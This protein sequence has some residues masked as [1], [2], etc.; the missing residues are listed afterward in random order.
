MFNS[1]QALNRK[2]NIILL[3]FIENSEQEQ[4][5][6]E[7]RKLCKEV[8]TVLRR[9]TWH[10]LFNKI[11][12]PV[13]IKYFYSEEM[14]EKAK[15]C[16]KYFDIDLVQ[17][18]YI[19]MAYYAKFMPPIPKIL[20]E[21]DTSIYTLNHSYERPVFGRILRFFD[22]LNWSHFQK[23]IYR[24]FDRIVAFSEDDLKI[25]RNAS[26]ADKVSILP[27]A[28]DADSYQFSSE[29]KKSIDI[30]F[31]GHML[32]YPNLDGLNYFIR[33]ILPL[34]KREMPEI[35]LSVVGSGIKEVESAIQKDSNIDIVGEVEEIRPYLSKAKVMV[36]PIRLGAGIKVKI[37]EA[38]AAGVPVVATR[39]AAKGLKVVLGKDIL[40]ADSP[41]DFA[42]K[43]LSLIKDKSQRIA[44]AK[45]ARCV[46]ETHYDVKQITQEE[47][48]LYES[49]YNPG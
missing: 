48:L 14:E 24:Y 31:I 45:N 28:I 46:V 41:S 1:L 40:I 18:E 19:N 6:P 9:P 17:I 38:M 27:I 25:I 34:I 22:W 13:F 21:H 30:L 3:S 33:K 15:F 20:I 5:I 44:I 10:A 16:F 2:Y 42:L 49:M 32:H 36:A 35:R 43:V 47:S 37:L 23:M 12:L 7:L 29:A 26:P 11:S 8:F 4:Y 39:A